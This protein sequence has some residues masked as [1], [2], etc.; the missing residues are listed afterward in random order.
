M[1]RDLCSDP[2]INTKQQFSVSWD[3]SR[4][5]ERWLEKNPPP[6]IKDGYFRC[7]VFGNGEPRWEYRPTHVRE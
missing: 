7:A 3:K 2:V 5:E 6:P 4:G 1:N